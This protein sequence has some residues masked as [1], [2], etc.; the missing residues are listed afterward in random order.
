MAALLVSQVSASIV[1]TTPFATYAEAAGTDTASG[2]CN[3][4]WPS[5]FAWKYRGDITSTDDPCSG[6]LGVAP[7]DP[8]CWRCGPPRFAFDTRFAFSLFCFLWFLAVTEALGE[9]LVAGTVAWWAFEKQDDKG[10]APMRK[11][12]KTTFRYHLGTVMF[13]AFVVALVQFIE[14]VVWYLTEQAK[15]QKNK[16]MEYIGRCLQCCL[17]CIE[18]SIKAIN[19]HAYIQVAL[20]GTTFCRSAISGMT[21]IMTN[22]ARFAASSILSWCVEITGKGFVIVFTA[23]LG[24]LIIYEGLHSGEGLTIV[25]FVAAAVLGHV[26]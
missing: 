1:P 4:F 19:R 21:L 14:A 26:V 2:K 6:N 7:A 11:A 10:S 3:D 20:N 16:V 5:G 13:G 22:L 9:I 15:A 12:F 18:K 8:L 17:K 23:V 25:P 24:Y